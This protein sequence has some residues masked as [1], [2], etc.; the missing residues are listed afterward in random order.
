MCNCS[1]G[2]GVGIFLMIY[3]WTFPI[4]TLWTYGLYP[5]T[6]INL[7]PWTPKFTPGQCKFTP[8]NNFFLEEP[9][10]V[11]FL[12]SAWLNK[13]LRVIQFWA[14]GYFKLLV[15]IL[16]LKKWEINEKEWNIHLEVEGK[17]GK[18][19]I[20]F[21]PHFQFSYILTGFKMIFG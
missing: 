8:M 12:D 9:N 10:S 2:G 16:I 7:T 21:C 13:G 11:F 6:I 20:I 4:F 19:A 17:S 18:Q 15:F 5:W 1:W 3:S 14:T